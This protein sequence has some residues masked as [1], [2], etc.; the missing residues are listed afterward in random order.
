VIQFINVIPFVIYCRK[1]GFRKIM[2]EKNNG[3]K[4]LG[5][6]I[7]AAR[8]KNNMT[9]LELGKILNVSDKT[10][11]KWERGAGYPDIRLIMPLADALH[12]DARDILKGID[13]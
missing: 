9:Q 12:V 6:L 7:S 1:Y 3:K 4:R 8:K 2:K 5:E 11:L 10:I 13:R